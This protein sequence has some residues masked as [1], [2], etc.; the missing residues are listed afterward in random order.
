M[1]RFPGRALRFCFKSGQT[2]FA[3]WRSLRLIIIWKLSS[4]PCAVFVF[5]GTW[6]HLHFADMLTAFEF[7]IVALQCQGQLIQCAMPDTHRWLHIAGRFVPLGQLLRKGWP[8]SGALSW[9]CFETAEATWSNLKFHH[10]LMAITC[11]HW[12][13]PVDY[14]YS[15]FLTTKLCICWLPLVSSTSLKLFAYDTCFYV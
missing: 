12:R 3:A 14:Q 7:L 9:S 13:F 6:L 10:A 4:T 2:R 8:R 5:F 15:F 11:P 1:F